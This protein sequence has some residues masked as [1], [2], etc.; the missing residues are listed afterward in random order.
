MEGLRAKGYKTELIKTFTALKKGL[1]E[2]E[3][4]KDGLFVMDSM[5]EE[6]GAP[7]VEFRQTLPWITGAGGV[8][9]RN[10]MPASGGI[11]GFE[12]N[13]YFRVWLEISKGHICSL[14]QMGLA[15]RGIGGDT[16]DA[17]KL[18]EEYYKTLH[19]SLGEGQGPGSLK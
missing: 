8:H 10:L 9:T 7:I 14:G 11:P 16:E 19:P 5:I 4:D 12:N 2:G 18:I 17:V 3:L 15:T 6:E 13:N 1:S